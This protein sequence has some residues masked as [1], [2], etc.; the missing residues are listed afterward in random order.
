MTHWSN[1]G[2]RVKA[3][4]M[5]TAFV[6]GF[7]V[8]SFPAIAQ[9]ATY[10][11]GPTRTYK[12]LSAVRALVNPGDVVEIDGDATYAGDVIFD[13]A[14]TAAQK[15]TV[16]GIRASGKR[17]GDLGRREHH[18][19]AG[20]PLRVR[21]ARHHER[22]EPLL[23]P[24]RRRRDDARLG[25]P[26]LSEAGHP[27]GRRGLGLDAARVHRGAPLRGRYAGSS[28]LHGDRRVGVPDRGL[29]HAVQ[30]RAR[31]QRRQRREVA[32]GAQRDL[33]QLDRGRAL[34]RA[35]A[36]RRGRG[37]GGIGS[38]GLRR[39]RQCPREAQH[40][41]RRALRRRRHGPE[42]RSLPAS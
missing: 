22:V 10:Q 2:L 29:P 20:E 19:G 6:V 4:I 30:L 26:R 1:A 41:L 3:L 35:R 37:A 17:P 34:P 38:R 31:R 5:R 13:K 32:R 27:R 9:A 21:G 24:P 25:R 33:L 11:V 39:G 16:R 28:D 18:R 36:D 42:Q 14:G 40:Q 15:I 12:Q 7:F 23:L 8:V